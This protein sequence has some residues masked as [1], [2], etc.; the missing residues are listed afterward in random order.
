MDYT[1][2]EH[3]TY[4]NITPTEYFGIT[5]QGEVIIKEKYDD[6]IIWVIKYDNN[7]YWLKEQDGM[8]TNIMKWD[9]YIWSDD[10]LDLKGKSTLTNFSQGFIGRWI[11]CLRNK[12]KL[13]KKY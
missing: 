10:Y 8:I 5:R 12:I 11:S 13:L 3:R 7:L 1:I 2:N 4:N 9:D 6:I